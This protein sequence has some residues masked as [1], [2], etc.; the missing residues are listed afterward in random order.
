MFQNENNSRGFACVTG[1]EH[2]FNE[3]VKLNRIEFK[4]KKLVIDKAK[5]SP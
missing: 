5:K 4:E 2:V 1:P 3:L